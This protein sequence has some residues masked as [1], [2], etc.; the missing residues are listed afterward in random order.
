M[1]ESVLLLLEIVKISSK[2]MIFLD[3]A[4]KSS[5]STF[6]ADIFASRRS[7]TKILISRGIYESPHEP[8]VRIERFCDI[9]A[10]FY[11]FKLRTVLSLIIFLLVLGGKNSN[12]RGNDHKYTFHGGFVTE[13]WFP[14][15]LHDIWK[16]MRFSVP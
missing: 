16:N 7:Y 10:N 8:R 2:L 13:I 1:A 11:F 14:E 15:T 12:F 5:E 6:R 3:F 9:R 4:R